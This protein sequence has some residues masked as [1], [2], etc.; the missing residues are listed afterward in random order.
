MGRI[1]SKQPGMHEGENVL[2]T[3]ALL[4]KKVHVEL[5]MIPNLDRNVQ[6]SWKQE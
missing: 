2:D 6:E 1:I 3:E 5:W 4:Y